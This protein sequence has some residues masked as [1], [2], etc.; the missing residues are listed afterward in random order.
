MQTT[1][2]N[3]YYHLFDYRS[4]TEKDK[5]ITYLLGLV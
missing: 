1:N 4:C 3:Y 2:K 5:I